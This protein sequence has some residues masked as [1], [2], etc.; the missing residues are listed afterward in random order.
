[1]SELIITEIDRFFDIV[2]EKAGITIEETSQLME[3]EMHHIERWAKQ[4]SEEGM[5]MLEY[6]FFGSTSRKVRLS[7]R[8][9]PEET[10]SSFPGQSF[11]LPS[12]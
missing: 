12:I 10:I 2:K 7:V 8:E 9:K 6:P 4:L 1:M 5:M 3:I 11:F